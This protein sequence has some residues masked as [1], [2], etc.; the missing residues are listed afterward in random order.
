MFRMSNTPTETVLNDLLPC[1]DCGRKPHMSRGG[2]SNN[3]PKGDFFVFC[4]SGSCPR[5]GWREPTLEEASD[6]WNSFHTV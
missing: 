2:R 1:R 5:G 3:D 6:K 4:P